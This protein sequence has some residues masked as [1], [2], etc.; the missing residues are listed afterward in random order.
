[1]S[2]FDWFAWIAWICW[3]GFVVFA[4]RGSWHMRVPTRDAFLVIG[5][6]LGAAATLILIVLFTDLPL[7]EWLEKILPAGLVH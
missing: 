3:G 5:G 6:A 1:M 4:R 7:F 2:G